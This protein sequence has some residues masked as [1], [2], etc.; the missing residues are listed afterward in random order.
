YELRRL[1]SEFKIRFG[2]VFREYDK[3]C[4]DKEQAV[5]GQAEF[6]A[7]GHPL[8]EAV[9]EKIFEKYGDD[10]DKGTVFLDPSGS[11]NGFIWFLESMI[12]DGTGSVAGKRIFALYQDNH[13]NVRLVSPSILWDLKP[14]H[15]SLTPELLSSVGSED[16][17]LGFAVEA[18]LPKYL[19]ELK[20]QREHDAEIKR[21]Y[22]VR[23]LQ[24]LILQSEGKLLDYE[25]R[26]AKGENIP[27][28]TIQNE[29]RNKEE[30]ER[31]KKQL[32]K[33][34]EAEVNLLLSPP[35][36][37]GVVAVIPKL[38]VDETLKEDKEIE[39]IGMRVA[40]E[41]EI[42]QDRSP[43]D[44]A[45]QNLG[46]DIR[47]RA[48]DESIRYIEVKARAGEGKIALTP[49]EWLMAHRLGNEYWLYI[50]VN[51][52]NSP[53]LYAIQNPAEKLKPEEE[54]EIVRYIVT[55]WKGSAKKEKVGV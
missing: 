6:V 44:V 34:I 29:R 22:G 14:H 18:V 8:L 16:S 9:V 46:F 20:K 53:E 49:N 45:A 38:P 27:E 33:Q 15:A 37:L 7:P 36:I 42:A 47:S 25:T 41:F 28:A 21:K 52:A 39:E 11:M 13:N 1:P 3:I 40:M 50:V 10:V 51:A 30:L 26:R 19:D 48:P 5:K 17:I 55:D 12:N 54:V 43:E 23:S 32:E 24:E 2:E 31:R 4:F 35:K